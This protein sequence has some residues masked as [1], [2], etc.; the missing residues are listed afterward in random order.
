MTLGSREPLK[1][2]NRITSLEF[3][4]VEKLLAQHSPDSGDLCPLPENLNEE[5][6]SGGAGAGGRE[7]EVTVV[8]F[9]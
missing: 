5:E 2:L 9:L 3:V 8:A 7:R 6:T 1:A 4:L